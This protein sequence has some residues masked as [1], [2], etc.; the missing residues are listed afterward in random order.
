MSGI[1]EIARSLI[2]PPVLR[3]GGVLL[4][5]LKLSD[6]RDFVGM[7]SDRRE[8][9]LL[10]REIPKDLTDGLCILGKEVVKRVSGSS[11][12]FAVE[13]GGELAGVI[14]FRKIN[15]EDRTVELVAFVKR[16]YR[17]RGI[18]TAAMD[19]L[20]RFGFSE[21]GLNRIYFYVDP[22]NTAV[23]AKLDKLGPLVIQEGCLRQNE[24]IR[25]QF[26]DDVVYSILRED[27]I[28]LSKEREA[29]PGRI[30]SAGLSAVDVRRSAVNPPEK[31]SILFK[32]L[33]LDEFLTVLP[34]VF[35][36]IPIPEENARQIAA[37]Y[38]R[39]REHGDYSIAVFPLAKVLRQ[40]PQ[41]I[42][43]AIKSELE[44][45]GLRN[46]FEISTMGP[47]INLKFL[48]SFILGGIPNIGAEFGKNDTMAGL[49]ALVEWVS[50]NPTGPLHIG[51][52]PLGGFRRFDLSSF[53]CLRSKSYKRIL[54]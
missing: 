5:P 36:N 16:E 2:R 54:C 19:R 31:K 12:L 17:G 35:P 18:A 21:L 44:K 33:I 42:A 6:A 39:E 45:G 4:R 14:G 27:W 9:S 30:G 3:T 50:A 49:T 13:V 52:G 32:K 29:M 43:L 23:R 25:G 7:F 47:Y 40:K 1:L 26:V 20:V 41:D 38:S 22:R 34:R 10:W 37:T 46:Y 53:N 51:H 11:C 15:K 28:R 8:F 24:H 48:P